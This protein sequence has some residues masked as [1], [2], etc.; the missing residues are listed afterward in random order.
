[1]A[2]ESE[3]SSAASELDGGGM[4]NFA[5]IRPFPGITSRDE[6]AEEYKTIFS[7]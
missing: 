4:K 3:L 7:V 2:Y 5:D 1:M 6:G